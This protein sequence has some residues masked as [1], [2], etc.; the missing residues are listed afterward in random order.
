M[1]CT[2]ARDAIEVADLSELRAADGSPLGEHLASCPD[3]RRLAAVVR[4]GT[5]QL[6]VGTL[7]RATMS[8]RRAR[9]VTGWSSVAAAATIVAA[10]VVNRREPSSR[11]E[12]R[13]ASLPVARQ[14]TLEVSRGQQAAVLKTSDPKITV[15]W[16]SSGE[17]K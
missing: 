16:L 7:R 15:I 17:G 6:S 14:V 5:A 11:P 9:R 8:R 3:C 1:T 13:L 4:R 2:E 12:P 10:V